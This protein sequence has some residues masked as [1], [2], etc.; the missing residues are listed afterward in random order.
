MLR[1]NEELHEVERQKIFDKLEQ[2]A[3]RQEELKELKELEVIRQKE[4]AIERAKVIKRNCAKA[5]I[6]QQE[7]I[8]AIINRRNKK[9]SYGAI[10]Q[11]EKDKVSR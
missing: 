2:D 11:A 10:V 6:I 8:K 9:D 3:I 4:L 1:K 5:V 7:E